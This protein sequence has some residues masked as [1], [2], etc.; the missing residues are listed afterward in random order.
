M[1]PFLDHVTPMR[2]EHRDARSILA[3]VE[4]LL[5][6][7]LIGTGIDHRLAPQRRGVAL[8]VVVEYLQRSQVVGVRIECLCVAGFAGESAG[9]TQTRKRDLAERLALGVVDAHDAVRVLYVLRDE[10]VAHILR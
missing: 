1:S 10:L 9:I 6:D 2:D 4:N 5:G 7:V 8:H 3:G